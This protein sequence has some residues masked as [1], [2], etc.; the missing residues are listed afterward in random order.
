MGFFDLF[1][2]KP[3]GPVWTVDL[4]DVR[5]AGTT[6]QG[7]FAYTVTWRKGPQTMTGTYAFPTRKPLAKVLA[8]AKAE[9]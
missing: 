2:S 7:L 5:E 6:D 8:L 4:A 3:S 9:C 1:K